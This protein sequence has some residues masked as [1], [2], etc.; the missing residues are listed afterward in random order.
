MP[1]QP[2]LPTREKGTDKRKDKEDVL[3]PEKKGDN[4]K[5]KM[6][7][8]LISHDQIEKRLHEGSTCYA[9]V[10]READRNSE[11]QILGHIK[12]ILEEFFE[13]LPQNL[14][15]SCPHCETFNMLLI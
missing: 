2:K 4:G 7:I 3:N 13:A 8:N 10:A 9:L 5:D 11:E 12:P 14:P 6:K 15:V 1:N